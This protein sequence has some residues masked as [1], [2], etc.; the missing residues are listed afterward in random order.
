LPDQGKLVEILTWMGQGNLQG[1]HF[2]G[3]TRKSEMVRFVMVN[4]FES[5]EIQTRGG[6]G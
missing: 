5:E 6:V 4:V 3:M 1:V 2:W